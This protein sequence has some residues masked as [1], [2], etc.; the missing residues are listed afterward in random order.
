MC[1]IIVAFMQRPF[2]LMNNIKKQYILVTRWP[3]SAIYQC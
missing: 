1:Y 2:K 3:V